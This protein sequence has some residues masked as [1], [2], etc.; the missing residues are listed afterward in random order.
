MY[1]T[2]I[3]HVR[4]SEFEPVIACWVCCKCNRSYL[5]T[6]SAN[7]TKWSNTLKQF[8]GNLPT[9]CLSGFDHFVKL[10]LKG[11][12]NYSGFGLAFMSILVS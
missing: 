12:N 9:N 11:L 4:N 6:L 2:P 5:G 7:L 1:F 3:I 8:V 10:A